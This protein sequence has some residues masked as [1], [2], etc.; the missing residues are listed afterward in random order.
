MA[1]VS[2]TSKASR[3]ISWLLSAASLLPAGC[4][5]TAAGRKMEG[6]TDERPV[7][8]APE[9]TAPPS[10]SPLIGGSFSTGL[11][12]R[13]NAGGFFVGDGPVQQSMLNLN[14]LS[15]PLQG[16]SG[17]IWSNADYG[18]D[19]ASRGVNEIDIG[20]S[21]PIV[22]HTTETHSMEGRI[23]AQYWMFPTDLIG[24]SVASVDATF[25]YTHHSGFTGSLLGRHVFQGGEVNAGEYLQ[26][27]LSQNTPIGPGV[28]SVGARFGKG[29]QFFGS[30][31][32]YATPLAGYD[33]PLSS[34]FSLRTEVGYQMS[35][36]SLQNGA[37][38]SCGVTVTF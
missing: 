16:A 11:R 6:L 20:A 17:F 1:I 22:R 3:S 10:S 32:W 7:A 5:S 33:L 21:F 8:A 4:V 38:G 25:N 35:D 29:F 26:L 28:L 12:N 18:S 27:D 31:G 30:D 23:G 36:G 2:T 14:A 9:S 24:S 34:R 13:Y 37:L 19:P 15:G